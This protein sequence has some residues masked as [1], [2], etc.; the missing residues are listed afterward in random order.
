MLPTKINNQNQQG[1]SIL[2]L[3]VVLFVASVL[4][5][6]GVPAFNGF[7]ESGRMAAAAILLTL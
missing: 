5:G 7:M 1:F 3:M 2:E 4:I 6:I